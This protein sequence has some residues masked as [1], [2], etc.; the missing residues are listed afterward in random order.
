LNL[1]FVF[2]VSFY[3][4]FF[5]WINFTRGN[6]EL[7][8]VIVFVSFMSW[9]CKNWSQYIEVVHI[10]YMF[11]LLIFFNVIIIW[12]MLNIYIVKF[13]VKCGIS[14]SCFCLVTIQYFPLFI[15][16]CYA[17]IW[18]MNYYELNYLINIDLCYSCENSF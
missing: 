2:V 14:C 10:L 4:L 6:T 7:Y 12:N 13:R 18:L 17:K 3:D 1:R 11:D 15:V 9:L 8:F 5:S 16:P